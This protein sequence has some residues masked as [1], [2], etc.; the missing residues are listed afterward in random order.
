[1]GSL[2]W[3]TGKSPKLV[4]VTIGGELRIGASEGPTVEA[5]GA[6]R[7]ELE[8]QEVEGG[9]RIESRGDCKLLV[10]PDAAL[11]V[12]AVGGDAAIGDVRG[13]L[14][15]QTIGGDLRLSRVG[16]TA[17]ETVGGALVANQVD[18]SLMADHVGADARVEGVRADVHLRS[19]G[20]DLRLSRVEGA[21]QVTAGGDVHV[22]LE[23]PPG[24]RSVIQAGGDLRCSLPERASVRVQIFAGGDMRVAVPT[25]CEEEGEGC[26]VRLGA[27]EAELELRAG[28]DLSLRSGEGK[29][30]RPEVDFGEAV[31][32]SVG[33]ELG[34]QMADLESRLNGLSG[35]LNFDTGRIGR[36][37]R[38]AMERAHRKAERARQR[39]EAVRGIAPGVPDEL[40]SEE[41]R[42]IILQMLEQGKLSVDQADSLLQALE[43]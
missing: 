39:A 7:R 29:W 2:R 28:G 13:Q 35:E 30:A 16:Q 15:L 3:E 43:D 22:S 5:Q 27:E 4:L 10:P 32:A 33:A 12:Q 24:S 37:L 25:E 19:V 6:D 38:Q 23:P 31:A 26:L 8:V 17:V 34:A 14:L 41:E 20:G 18:G 1:M 21:A 11:E 42:M 36:R 40:P 9:L